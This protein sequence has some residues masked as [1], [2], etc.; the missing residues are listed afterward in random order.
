MQPT[1]AADAGASVVANLP[2]LFGFASGGVCPAAARCRERGA[3]LP[4]LFTL[5]LALR[6]GRF[7]F[8]GTVPRVA[9]AGRY[10]APPPVK[11]GLSSPPC[12]RA[13]TRLSVRLNYHIEF[14][15]K[16]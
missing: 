11:P 15:D 7:L 14:P 9:P 6:F 10:P 5:T 4:H 2:R 13:V 12:G 8:C 1:R 3:L 16:S